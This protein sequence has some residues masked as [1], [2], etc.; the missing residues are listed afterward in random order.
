MMRVDTA[1][2]KLGIEYVM[3]GDEAWAH[4]PMHEQRTGRPDSNPSWSINTVTG[5]FLCFSCGYRGGVARLVSDLTGVPLEDAEFYVPK[6]DPS[7]LLRKLQESVAVEKAPPRPDQ[8]LFLSFDDVPEE[9]L[10]KRHISREAADLYGIRWDFYNRCWVF[11]IR[12]SH[13][14]LL[15][16]QSKRGH[17]VRNHPKGVKKS[18]SV[19]G[20]WVASPQET[21]CV[22]ES[23]LD[24]ALSWQAG[25]TGVALFGAKWSDAQVETL[26]S[27]PRVI[28]AL[29][30]DK[31]GRTAQEELAMVLGRRGVEVRRVVWPDHMKDFGD[32]P[33]K[34]RRL[35]VSTRN[36]LLDALENHA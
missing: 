6:A 19:F 12:D 13:G 34:V 22:V 28:L 33:S 5:K 26:V 31:A 9:F 14:E 32:A 30:N 11:P 17:R 20:S 29:D 35:L 21:V 8:A 10:Q 24:A 4:C 27:Y 18:E 2:D 15:G 16:W 36:P 3:R 25:I 7:V 23:P 1:L